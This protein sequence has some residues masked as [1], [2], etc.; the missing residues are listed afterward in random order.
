MR[1]HFCGSFFEP[2]CTVLVIH[3]GKVGDSTLSAR[4]KAEIT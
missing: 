3:D 4:A 1:L 2:F